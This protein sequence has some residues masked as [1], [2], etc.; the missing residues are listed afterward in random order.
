MR[1]VILN[2]EGLVVKVF[3]F[4]VFHFIALYVPSLVGAGRG[5]GGEA[6]FKKQT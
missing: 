3:L 6:H 1:A 5:P 2:P 4:M